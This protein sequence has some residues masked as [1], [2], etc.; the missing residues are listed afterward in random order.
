M[1]GILTSGHLLL[2]LGMLTIDA[3]TLLLK[4]EI[5]IKK[6]T[7]PLYSINFVEFC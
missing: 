4:N 5:S 7:L 2:S 3:A 1:L 6:N